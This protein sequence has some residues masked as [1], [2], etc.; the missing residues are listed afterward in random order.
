MTLAQSTYQEPSPDAVPAAMA[1]T[2]SSLLRREVPYRARPLALLAMAAATMVPTLSVP[3]VARAADARP[4]GTGDGGRIS[5]GAGETLV[6]RSTTKVSVLTIAEGGSI[7]APDGYSLTV[8]V[9]GVETGSTLPALTDDGGAVTFTAPGTY[10]GDVVITVAVANPVDFESLTFPLRQAVYVDASGVVAANSVLAAVLGGDLTRTSAKGL[11]LRSRGEAFNGV[12]AS[13]GEYTL[14]RPAIGFTGNGRCD[15]VGYGAAVMGTGENTRLVLDGATISNTGVVRTAVIADATSTVVVKNSVI[16][17]ADGVLPAD[18]VPTSD[19]A[20]MIVVPWMLGLSGNVRATNLLGAN[21]IAGY[22]NSDVHS[23]NW[24]ALSVDS[25]SD[26]TLAAINCRVG[27]T[28]QDGYGT[29]AIGNV[30]EH[31]L[32]TRFDV[33]SYATINW[34]GAAVHYGDSTREA[35]E[36]LN[37]ELGLGLSGRELAAI[38]PQATVI[39]SRRFGV[40][41]QSTGPVTIDGGTRITTKE[42]MFLSKASAAAVTVDGSGGAELHAGNGILFQLMD[43]DNPGHVD[44]S[45]KPWTSETSGV[46]TEPSGEPARTSFDV[47][48]AHDTDATATFTDMALAGDFY[49]SIRGDGTGGLDGMNLVLTFDNSRIDGVLSAT[50]ARHRVST[51]TSAQYRELGEVTNTVHEVVNNGVIVE[52]SGSTTWTVTGTSYLS[53][54]VVGPDATIAGSGG[55]SPSMTVDGVATSITAGTYTGAITLTV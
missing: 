24:G 3:A 26:C 37:D 30:T 34:G 12:Y 27:N 14:L 10:R 51:I 13:G 25:G 20:Y 19:P 48:A 11:T 2:G 52:L 29:Y 22:V 43:N 33:A 41:W 28:G 21:T 1:S 17:V 4:A 9:D 6:V 40:M 54:L 15:F 31:L 32:G 23:E 8:T 44:V 16:S 5:V 39:D 55:G 38:R 49:N 36:Q 45:G 46:Y 53:K 18:Y 50:T 7:V 47:T 35:V 42:T